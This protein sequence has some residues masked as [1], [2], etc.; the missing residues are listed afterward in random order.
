MV[1]E[2]ISDRR[3]GGLG[4]GLLVLP[5]DTPD[6]AVCYVAEPRQRTQQTRVENRTVSLYLAASWSVEIPAKNERKTKFKL[7]KISRRGF[8]SL[9]QW[10]LSP[11][12]DSAW[13]QR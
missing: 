3:S 12:R 8:A 11:G 13:V 4:K 7:K 1:I 2:T 6:P 9:T 5:A 10:E